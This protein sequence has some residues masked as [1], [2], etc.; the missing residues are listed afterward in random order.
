MDNYY[1]IFRNGKMIDYQ[2]QNQSVNASKDDTAI[3]F[4]FDP[5]LT[6]YPLMKIT[7]LF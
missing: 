4:K 1:V 7:I 2:P 6:N 3:E 5:I